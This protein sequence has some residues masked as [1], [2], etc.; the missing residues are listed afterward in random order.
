VAAVFFSTH[1]L[2]RTHTSVLYPQEALITLHSS[3]SMQAIS[4]DYMYSLIRIIEDSGLVYIVNEPQK[5]ADTM[6][7]DRSGGKRME[8]IREVK[9]SRS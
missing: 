7:I 2:Q 1:E 9:P 6:A 3:S 5:P 4:T 8:E